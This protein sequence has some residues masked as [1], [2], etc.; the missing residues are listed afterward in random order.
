MKCLLRTV[1]LLL[2]LGVDQ[3]QDHGKSES[4]FRM[5]CELVC[6]ITNWIVCINPKFGVKG[7]DFDMNEFGIKYGKIAFKSV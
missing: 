5:V 6:I 4:N 1:R 3:I 2:A 7:G